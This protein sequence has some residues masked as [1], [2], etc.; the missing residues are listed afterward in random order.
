[1][2]GISNR[3]KPNVSTSSE[4]K[5]HRSYKEGIAKLPVVFRSAGHHLRNGT[6][7]KQKQQ[8]HMNI[9]LCLRGHKYAKN[10]DNRLFEKSYI[11]SITLS[12]I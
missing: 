3:P 4:T 12:L 2:V 1:V 6:K 8:S 9:A 10:G 5:V 11:I 7:Q